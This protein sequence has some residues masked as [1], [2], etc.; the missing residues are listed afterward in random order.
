[1]SP[2]DQNLPEPPAPAV[3]AAAVAAATSS[4]SGIAG[5]TN[6]SE[7]DKKTSALLTQLESDDERETQQA[8][9]AL[10]KNGKYANS[11]S[12]ASERKKQDKAKAAK[13][14]LEG[15]KKR[16]E[17][18]VQVIDNLFQD[19]KDETIYITRTDLEAGK[20]VLNLNNM[21]G[22]GHVVLTNDLSN[23]EN[24]FA[25]NITLQ[26][27]SFP[28]DAEN[29][30]PDFQST[31]GS[32]QGLLKLHLSHLKNMTVSIKTKVLTG[33]LEISHCANLKVILSK[34]STI[35]TVQADLSNNITIRMEDAPSGSNTQYIGQDLIPK[36][37]WGSDSND[38]IFHAGVSNFTI[39]LVRD[40]ICDFETTHDYIADG[41]VAVGNTTAEEVQFV[42]SILDGS[43]VTERVLRAGSATGTTVGGVLDGSGGGSGARAM[44]ER[45]MKE[46]ERKKREIDRAVEKQLGGIKILDKEGKEVPVVKKSPSTEEGKSENKSQVG[47][48]IDAIIAD[49]EAQKAK[50]NEAFVAGEY[51]QAILLYTLALDRASELPDAQPKTSS[52]SS[53]SNTKPLFPRHIVLS[54]RSACFLKLGHHDKALEDGN[55]AERLDPTYVKGTFRKGLALHA[56]GR[57]RDAIESLASALKLEPK[58]KQIKQALQFAEV[59]MTQEM[60]KMREG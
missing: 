13:S 7:W 24:K 3:A 50:G 9:E 56:M 12:E 30:A 35:V 51:A 45:E 59:R 32:I 53:E 60:R 46:V 49:C 21:T 38:R 36:L 31:P 15:Y 44:T 18:V 20:R 16:E 40:G 28:G 5:R 14:V 33:L 39:Q 55:E 48:D 27:K 47:E 57:Y 34:E 43:L 10:G 23:L 11:E 42:T 26:P 19:E 4:K 17:R 6:Y 54:N 58:N 2:S 29:S 37:Q 25:Q 41:A 1:M 52:S 22:P 8:N